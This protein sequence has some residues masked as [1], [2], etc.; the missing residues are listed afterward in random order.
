MKLTTKKFIN[1]YSDNCLKIKKLNRFYMCS[2]NNFN[3]DLILPLTACSPL[4]G[5]YSKQIA[6]IKE[7]YSNKLNSLNNLNANISKNSYS[8]TNK[9]KEV[10]AYYYNLLNEIIYIEKTFNKTFL[11]IFDQIINCINII[12]NN[13]NKNLNNNSF[14]YPL[15]NIKNNLKVFNY[16]ENTKLIDKNEFTLENLLIIYN[17]NNF[18]STNYDDFY[19]RFNNI[20]KDFKKIFY[21]INCLNINSLK[22]SVDIWHLISKGYFKQKTKVGEIGSS[23]M[24]HKINPIDFENAEGNFGLSN[25]YYLYID[26]CFMENNASNNSVIF[27]N[28]PSLLSYSLIGYSSLLKGINKLKI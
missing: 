9:N 7:I 26:K 12:E 2:Y 28:I 6:V 25:A 4:D 20:D 5:R 3:S 8:N 13:L 15:L 21:N 18:N 17:I 1:F 16:K 11:L 14:Y 27:E 22:L 24:P 10:I 23:T 19:Y